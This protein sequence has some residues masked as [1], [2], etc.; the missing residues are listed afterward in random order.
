MRSPFRFDGVMRQAI[1]QLKYR[2]LRALAQPLAKLLNNYLGTNPMPGEVLVPVPLHHKRLRERGYNQSSLLT[3]ELGKLT[4]LPVVDDCLIRLRHAPPQARTSTVDER[5][6]NV[7]GAFTCR[8]RRLQ[9]KQ[10]LL[11]D[12]V[13][14]SGATLDACAAALKAAGATAVWGLVLAREI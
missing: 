8:D 9:D 7:A 12:D 13:S 4:N 10:V 5:R 6:S 1:H 14:T 11:I 3:K 2:N